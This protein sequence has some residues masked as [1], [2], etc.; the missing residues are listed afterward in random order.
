MFK[1][2]AITAANAFLA[3]LGIAAYTR[4]MEARDFGTAMLWTGLLSLLDVAALGPF[5]YAL[6]R[7]VPRASAAACEAALGREFRR[8]G[9]RLL[10][11]ASALL[12]GGALAHLL[13]WWRSPADL[14]AFALVLFLFALALPYRIAQ[15][16]LT[17][18]EKPVALAWTHFLETAGQLGGIVLVVTSTRPTCVAFL[19]GM[20][21]GRLF[22][23]ALLALG[24]A[25]CRRLLPSRQPEPAATAPAPLDYRRFYLT[26]VLSALIGWLVA[27]SDRYVIGGLAGLEVVGYFAAALGFVSRP[28]ALVTATLTT[29]YK[30]A[31]FAA[32]AAVTE[33][34]L[35]RAWLGGA[36]G[37]GG[38]GVVGFITLGSWIAALYFPPEYARLI[39]P[40]LP[41]LALAAACTIATHVADNALIARGQTAALLAA[42]SAAIGVYLLAAV[43]LIRGGSLAGAAWARLLGQAFQLGLTFALLLRLRR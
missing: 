19:A 30:P 43:C 5:S 18:A 17:L 34:R 16:R 1:V 13:G 33:H 39:S 11:G 2:G 21:L 9:V 36:L 42:Q 6:L 3:F 41:L 35:L 23:Y 24:S 15:T 7:H 37:F 27:M 20:A 40:L 25:E 22:S 32:T 29:H 26:L 8:F 38:A 31:L 14:L 4:L 12:A 28:Y 10:T